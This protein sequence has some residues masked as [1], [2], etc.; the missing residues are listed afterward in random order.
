MA[1][2]M[3]NIT[4]RIPS[5]LLERLDAYGFKY[6][7]RFFNRSEF[8]QDAIYWRLDSIQFDADGT[9]NKYYVE[10]GDDEK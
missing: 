7:G 1:S 5:L 9:P 8:I 6:F 3:E 10:Y 2:G 4:V